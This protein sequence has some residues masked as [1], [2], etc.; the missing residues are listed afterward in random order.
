MKQKLLVDVEGD[1]NCFFR[2]LY[3][4]AVYNSMTLGENEHLHTQILINLECSDAVSKNVSALADHPQEEAGFR[5]RLTKYDTNSQEDAWVQC[6]RNYLSN[7]IMNCSHPE[8]SPQ[9]GNCSNKFKEIYDQI[10]YAYQE[11]LDDSTSI[12]Y[13]ALIDAYPSAFR[14]KYKNIPPANIQ[15]FA[16]FSADQVKRMGCT[17][18]PIDIA[19]VKELFEM[20]DCTIDLQSLQNIDVR[21]IA[22]IDRILARFPRNPDKKTFYVVNINENHYN[23]VLYANVDETTGGKRMKRIKHK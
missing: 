9:F 4:C 18:S 13:D 11:K 10:R 19:I 16:K 2:A 8:G 5:L 6:L 3:G 20:F 22:D 1:G 7:V 23:F 15:E 12:L 21:K 14:R 17:S